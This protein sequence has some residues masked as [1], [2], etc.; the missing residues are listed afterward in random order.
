M[1][2]VTPPSA[3]GSVNAPDTPDT[4]YRSGCVWNSEVLPVNEQAENVAGQ[5]VAEAQQQ[6]P[7][8]LDCDCGYASIRHVKNDVI[9]ISTQS[10]GCAKCTK[11]RSDDD[12]LRRTSIPQAATSFQSS[13][14][15]RRSTITAESLMAGPS[16]IHQLTDSVGHEHLEQRIIAGSS[17]NR[18]PND[19]RKT[20]TLSTDSDCL[21][22]TMSE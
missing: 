10:V 15:K 8:R 3:P 22:I 17:P 16:S 11:R 13:A 2:I 20:R 14:T 21:S 6:Q 18:P 19:E 12:N 5:C 4:G 7:K 1:S 9:S